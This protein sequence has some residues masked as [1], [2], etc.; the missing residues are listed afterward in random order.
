M[1]GKND[2]IS[3]ALLIQKYT[4]G[5]LQMVHLDSYIKSLKLS[6]F[7]RILQSKYNLL[8]TLYSVITRSIVSKLLQLGSDYP[9]NLSNSI[10]N[11]FWKETLISYNDYIEIVHKSLDAQHIPVWFNPQIK[12]DKKSLFFES[13]YKKGFMYLSDFFNDLG[14]FIKLDGIGVNLPFTTV[15]GLKKVICLHINDNYYAH[16]QLPLLPASINILQKNNKEVYN[17]FNQDIHCCA[18]H[19]HKWETLLELDDTFSWKSKYNALFNCTKDS[20]LLSLEYRIFHSV[21]GAN[22]YLFN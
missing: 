12:I 6:W 21:L 8:S 13:L 15:L 10:N 20:E 2:K 5:G 16:K 4:D 9:K 1:K 7:R 17:V 22:K 11:L 3:R 14:E 19:E 18:K